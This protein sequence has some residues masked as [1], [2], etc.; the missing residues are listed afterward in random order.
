MIRG[1]EHDSFEDRMKG[2]E[3]FSLGNRRLWEDITAGF[4]HVKWAYEKETLL[5]HVVAV[6]RTIVLN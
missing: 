2:L 1:V 4:Q 5:G 3:M 6:E